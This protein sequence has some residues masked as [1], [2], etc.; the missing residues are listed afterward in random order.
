MDSIKTQKAL[1]TVLVLSIFVVLLTSTIIIQNI[2]YNFA[3]KSSINQAKMMTQ[4]F[5]SNKHHL[6]RVENNNFSIKR[7]SLEYK[8]ID[9]KPDNFE[10]AILQKYLSKTIT[11]EYYEI[12]SYKNKTYLRYI[13]PLYIENSELK[14]IISVAIN[15]NN[16]QNSIVTINISIYITASLLFIIILTLLFFN[17]KLIFIPQFLKEQNNKEYLKKVKKEHI[18]LK[19]DF[20]S[21]ISHELRTPMNGIISMTHLI[22]QTDLTRRQMHYLKTIEKSSASL[23]NI[24]NNILDFSHIKSGELKL[25]KVDFNFYLLLDTIQLNNINSNIKFDIEYTQ[26]IPQ[27][28][29]G[30]IIKI[31]QILTYLL[32]N[33]LKFTKKG[34]IKVIITHKEELYKFTIE[35]SGIGMSKK[36]QECLF[37]S[38]SQVDS[39]NSREYN[40]VGLGLA[41]S[42]QL[43]ELMN[44]KIWVKS[45]L[46]KGSSFIFEI[47]LTEVTKDTKTKKIIQ[48]PLLKSIDTEKGLIHLAQNKTLYFDILND[49]YKNYKEFKINIIDEKQFEMQI[50]TLKTLSASIGAM[51]LNNILI[52]L[53]E[54]QDL[55]LI[56]A[57]YS[58]LAIV[59]N[60]IKILIEN[61]DIQNTDK[62]LLSDIRRSELFIS[63]QD[64][65]KTKK[66]KRCE[67]I[68]DEI[69]NYILEDTD[70]KLFNTIKNLVKK[71]KFKEATEL[72]N[73]N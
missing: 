50:H 48:T 55:S 73:E 67:P 41:L 43:I 11:N 18:Q 34:F 71:Y 36:H 23:L 4:Q 44:G 13:H 49:F 2:V 39:S 51:K 46:G 28:L 17:Y 59:L 22:L 65:L 31:E 9:N 54:N 57:V 10:T 20:I 24:I 63:L 1:N 35:D 52:Q 56:D 38:F 66:P 61:R 60:E 62:V 6:F 40:G 33:A 16:I 21:N 45:E 53:D 32:D 70:T 29:N 8:S 15:I 5:L 3:I 7:A 47:S 26:D 37:K 58:E 64:A 30:D 27:Y 19:S 42:K 69:N 12:T 72:L 14:S 68:I 25:N